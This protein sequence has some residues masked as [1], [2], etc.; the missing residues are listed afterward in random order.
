MTP[1]ITPPEI[2]CRNATVPIDSEGA[3]T[4]TVWENLVLNDD[5]ISRWYEG[6]PLGLGLVSKAREQALD[7]GG[8]DGYTHA[9]IMELYKAKVNKIQ[10]H[11]TTTTIG[12]IDGDTESEGHKVSDGM[13]KRNRT[14]SRWM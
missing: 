14:S 8:K 10:A 13:P 6:T 3:I 4:K 11:K 9:E 5:G 7:A 12:N 1:D 2:V